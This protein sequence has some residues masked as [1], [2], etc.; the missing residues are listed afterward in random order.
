V[1][2]NVGMNKL[3]T[4]S[5][6]EIADFFTRFRKRNDS[7]LGERWGQPNGVISRLDKESK[8]AGVV[9]GSVSVRSLSHEFVGLYV[10]GRK[11]SDVIDWLEALLVSA[12]A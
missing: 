8:A 5:A 6:S 10:W 3:T 12:A 11:V 4:A 1:E 7:Y 9:D 2:L